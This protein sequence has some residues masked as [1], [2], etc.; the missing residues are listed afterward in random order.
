MDTLNEW[1]RSFR[2]GDGGTGGLYQGGDIQEEAGLGPTLA[3]GRTTNSVT[4]AQTHCSPPPVFN[5]H[6]T[7]PL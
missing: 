7:P 5:H 3:S 2:G 1:K 6:P 4:A